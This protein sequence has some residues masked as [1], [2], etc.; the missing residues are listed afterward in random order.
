MTYRNATLDDL[1][2]IVDIYNSTI[3]GRMVT[4]DVIPLKTEDKLTWFNNHNPSNR[5]IWVVLNEQHEI[6]GWI[7][8]QDFYGRPAYSGTAE[9]SIYLDEK[10]RGKGLGKKILAHAIS[11]CPELGIDTLLGF[12]FKHNSI[13][14]KLFSEMGFEE[15][16]DLKG[17]A[18][19]D[20]DRYS[21]IIVGKKIS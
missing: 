18:H 13:S 7:S 20:N 12:I 15:W 19:I 1:P 11:K 9:I 8:F 4:A 5:P 14:I 2:V 16:G 10:Y 6:I 17:I 3:P 21:L